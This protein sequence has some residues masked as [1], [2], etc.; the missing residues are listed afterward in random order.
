MLSVHP[1]DWQ[2]MPF[3]LLHVDLLTTYALQPLALQFKPI[4]WKPLMATWC[5][6]HINCLTTYTN[7][8]TASQLTTTHL[9]SI[10][11]A[12]LWLFALWPLALQWWQYNL[13][14]S[15]DCLPYNPL[16]YINHLLKPITQWQLMATC[17]TI[18]NCLTTYPDHL[19]AAYL[20]TAHST[21]IPLQ[22]M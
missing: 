17:L 3:A 6:I 15:L 22:L 18:Y 10:P 5:T 9:T 21:T 11:T 4:G 12:L 13:C 8:L 7:H 14:G 19:M 16:P 2:P 1:L 20:T